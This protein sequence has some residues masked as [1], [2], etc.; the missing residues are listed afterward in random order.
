M[1]D[2]GIFFSIILRVSCSVVMVFIAAN[3]KTLKMFLRAFGC[4]FMSN[5]AFAGIML[6]IWLAFKPNGMIY[7][8][9]AVYFAEKPSDI[10]NLI[11]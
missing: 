1:P 5:F 2:F 8:N 4:F 9:G 6:G 3:P 10:L 11:K 7:K